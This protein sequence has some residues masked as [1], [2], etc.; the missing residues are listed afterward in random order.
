V[1]SRCQSRLLGILC[2][3]SSMDL[4][5]ATSAF[6]YQFASP[7]SSSAKFWVHATSTCHIHIKCVHMIVLRA[8]CNN[9]RWRSNKVTRQFLWVVRHTVRTHLR[10]KSLTNVISV[11][12]CD[13]YF[14]IQNKQ[15]RLFVHQGRSDISF[16]F[17]IDHEAV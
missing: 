5:R 10:I 1:L 17:V 15:K 6:P 8:M 3:H 13:F 2:R 11:S 14:T 4:Q 7:S 16:V 12:Q 9:R